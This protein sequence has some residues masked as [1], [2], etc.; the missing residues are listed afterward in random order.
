METGQ[1][2]VGINEDEWRQA[3]MEAVVIQTPGFSPFPS[4]E[5]TPARCF[6]RPCSS[7]QSSG[8]FSPQVGRFKSGPGAP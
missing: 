8:V 2:H 4:D 5:S 6:L 1:L 3:D 7:A